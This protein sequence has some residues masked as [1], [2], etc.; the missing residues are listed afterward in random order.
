MKKLLQCI[1]FLLLVH[2]I[3]AQSLSW[4]ELVSNTEK[5]AIS[6]KYT[7]A[8][9]TEY[10][11]IS[12]IDK[13]EFRT[14]TDEFDVG[15]QEYT[16]RSSFITPKQRKITRQLSDQLNEEYSIKARERVADN[17]V[18]LYETVLDLYFLTRQQT[19]Q[20]E[21]LS[22]LND[23]QIILDK[24]TILDP[25]GMTMEIYDL[26][27]EIYEETLKL[28]QQK[29]VSRQFKSALNIDQETEINWVDFLSIPTLRARMEVLQEN[30]KYNPELAIEENRLNSNEIK[31][32][33]EK[34]SQDQ[35]LDFLQLKYNGPRK[36]LTTFETFSLGAGLILPTKNYNRD[37]INRI[38][39]D[40]LENEIE[41]EE[42]VAL[43]NK[44]IYAIMNKLSILD[45]E[46]AWLVERIE[47]NDLEKQL[48]DAEKGLLQNPA[49]VLKIK[50]KQLDRQ[51]ELLSIEQDMH[52]LH[53][54]LLE[55]TGAIFNDPSI[56]YLHELES[57]INN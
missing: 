41:L 54:E 47:N 31:L 38:D 10:P 40:I 17:Y 45:N 35:L 34:S 50:K 1:P 23:E 55:T 52:Q 37:R 46:R 14:E 2:L 39:R 36:N 13:L 7:E 4:T 56:N 6:D 19:I 30:I 22:L 15:R 8:A 29:L 25:A 18:E 33:L 26:E 12:I 21:L 24:Q 49:D 43:I 20:E 3:S 32:Q 28:E 42:I 5:D 16:F 53:I 48:L 44:D 51:E 57:S 9:N 27:E 11:D